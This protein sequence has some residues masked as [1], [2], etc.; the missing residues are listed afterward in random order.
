MGYQL[1]GML[2][3]VGERVETLLFLTSGKC[4]LIFISPTTTFFYNRYRPVAFV[5]AGPLQ[6]S[7][8][9]QVI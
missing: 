1:P 9:R 6:I 5:F 4:R 7:P 8:Q 2:D 3:F